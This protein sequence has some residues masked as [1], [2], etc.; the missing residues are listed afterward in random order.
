M[1]CGTGAS[2]SA[3]VSYITGKVKEKQIKAK[4]KGGELLINLTEDALF[5][6]GPARKAYEGRITIDLK[7]LSKAATHSQ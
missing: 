6:T 3:A 4:V 5:L 1:A 2:A 7:S